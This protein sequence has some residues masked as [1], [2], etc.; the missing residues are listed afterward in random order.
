M[1]ES[2]LPYT[3]NESLVDEEN[4]ILFTGTEKKML[5]LFE[6]C[7]VFQILLKFFSILELK[8]FLTL[9]LKH[10]PAVHAL[11][12]PSAPKMFPHIPRAEQHGT[13]VSLRQWSHVL[14]VNMFQVHILRI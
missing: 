8:E 5:E 1:N 7:A 14:F 9:M 13:G 4:R 3:D 6:E 11:V 2:R 10:R 12:Y